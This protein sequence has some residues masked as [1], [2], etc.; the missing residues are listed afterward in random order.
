MLTGFTADEVE[1]WRLRKSGERFR[2]TVMMAPIRGGDGEAPGFVTTT[3]DVT[4]G[5]RTSRCSAGCCTPHPT[6]W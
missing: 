1:G 3:Q 5:G 4:D 6:R 2:A